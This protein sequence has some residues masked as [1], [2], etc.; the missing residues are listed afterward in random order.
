MILAVGG[1]TM[2]SKCSESRLCMN[3]LEFPSQVEA[4][5]MQNEHLYAVIVFSSMTYI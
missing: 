4:S 1:E 5:H 2:R 3:L